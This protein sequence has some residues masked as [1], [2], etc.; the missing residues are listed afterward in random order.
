MDC[1]R[2]VCAIIFFKFLLVFT[3]CLIPVNF[4]QGSLATY[5]F[6]WNLEEILWGCIWDVE[7]TL[8]LVDD[9]EIE[10]F[11][12][13]AGILLVF[14]VRVLERWQSATLPFLPRFRKTNLILIQIHMVILIVYEVAKLIKWFEIHTLVFNASLFKLLDFAPSF[15]ISTFGVFWGYSHIN[16]VKRLWI[17]INN[18]LWT[19]IK[20][21]VFAIY[22]YWEFLVFN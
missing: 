4:L 22:C 17:L 11:I 13:A 19:S 2:I 14:T 16:K 5:F 1:A 20:K 3:I 6:V 9:C 10:K 12:G 15:N 7:R 21:R 8:L 18:E